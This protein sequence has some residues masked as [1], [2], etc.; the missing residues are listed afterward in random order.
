MKGEIKIE[1]RYLG[2]L[3]KTSLRGLNGASYTG[4]HLLIDT[5]KITYWTWEGECHRM[6][7]ILQQPKYANAHVYFR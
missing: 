1:G 2:I 4:F 3:Q 6:K 7:E 5:V